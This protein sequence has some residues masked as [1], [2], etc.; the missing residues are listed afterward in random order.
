[1]RYVSA[2]LLVVFIACLFLFAKPI[3]I[4]GL[5]VS[6]AMLAAHEFYQ[7]TLKEIPD[8]HKLIG[9][10][11]AG[12]LCGTLIFLQDLSMP[13]L[14]V[15]LLVSFLLYLKG[16]VDFQKQLR[17]LTLF[18]FGIVYVGLLFSYWGKIVSLPNWT[19]WMV[20]LLVATFFSDTG[21]YFAGHLFGKHKLAP[22]ISPGKTVE[23]YV[24]GIVFS[25]IGALLVRYFLGGDYPIIKTVGVSFFVSAFA[26]LGDLSESLI[27]RAVNA[28][29]SGRLIPGHG[30]LLDRV[31]ALLFAGPIVYYWAI[32]IK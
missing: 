19:F 27:K 32:Y 17:H 18:Y 8:L 20:L 31:D 30:G 14:T 28:K 1:M 2:A 13:V 9:V 21:A 7:L 6:L 4:S 3:F 16:A 11:F 23:G 22:R 25:I 24:G 29:D 26:P 12:G 15:A 5:I 10:V